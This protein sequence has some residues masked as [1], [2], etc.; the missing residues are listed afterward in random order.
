MKNK[1]WSRP[2]TN[3]SMESEPMDFMRVSLK[4]ADKKG[5]TISVSQD[6]QGAALGASSRA[7]PPNYTKETPDP[8]KVKT[9]TW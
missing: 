1:P 5:R 9:V 6:K 3:G 8:A 2:C 4:L 7:T